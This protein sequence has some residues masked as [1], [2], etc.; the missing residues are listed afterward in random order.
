[1]AWLEILRPQKTVDPSPQYDGICYHFCI[2]YV[3]IEVE[4]DQKKPIAQ[5]EL[6]C[7]IVLLCTVRYSLV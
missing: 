4:P 2:E 5:S 6:S 3:Y 7:I 1:V